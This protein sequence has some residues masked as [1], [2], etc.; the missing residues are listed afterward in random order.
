MQPAPVS[1]ECF[2]GNNGLVHAARQ[3]AATYTPARVYDLT[4][5]LPEGSYTKRKCLISAHISPLRCKI[6]LSI[7]STF[8]RK[9]RAF[10][11][12]PQ[13][14]LIILKPQQATLLYL[15]RHAP[16]SLGKLHQSSS[17]PALALPQM[18]SS[19]RSFKKKIIPLRL[20]RIPL[21]PVSTASLKTSVHI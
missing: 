17:C 9:L 7:F 3:R 13:A 6:K 10:I 18:A 5:A 21:I 12:L 20:R 14:L 19:S 4:D 1:F 11:T 2:F 16:L 8:L 15:H